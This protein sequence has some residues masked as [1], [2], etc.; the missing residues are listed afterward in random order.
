M[1]AGLLAAFAVSIPFDG[2]IYPLSRG[3]FAT[4]NTVLQVVA[5]FMA[6]GVVIA[7]SQA[8]AG[9][10]GVFAIPA[11]YAAGSVTKAGLLG[12]FVL[13]RLRAIERARASR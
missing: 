3:I 9:P 5:A 1:T 11:G 2:V 4:H 10:I 8:L 7:V 13:W 6:F 12:V